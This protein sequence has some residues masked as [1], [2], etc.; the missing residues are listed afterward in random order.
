[1]VNSRKTRFFIL[2]ALLIL[3]LV[4]ALCIAVFNAKADSGF[5][6]NEQGAELRLIRNNHWY[7]RLLHLY[8]LSKSP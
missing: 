5:V 1:M 7:A 6:M 8:R 3:T 2:C 4:S